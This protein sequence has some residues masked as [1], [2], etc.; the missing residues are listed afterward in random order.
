[1]IKGVI[2]NKFL[3][4]EIEKEITEGIGV[5]L[6]LFEYGVGKIEKEFIKAFSVKGTSIEII[7]SIPYF[8][9]LHGLPDMDLWK[10]I[11]PKSLKKPE[12]E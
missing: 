7:G 3:Y 2:I 4:K 12:R 5:S 1:M 11:I 8:K 9:E 10:Q 6:R